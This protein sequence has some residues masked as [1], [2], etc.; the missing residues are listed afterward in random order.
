MS[1]V[2]FEWGAVVG[3]ILFSCGVGLFVGCDTTVPIFENPQDHPL[4]YS[5]YGQIS[6]SDGGIIRVEPLRDST[7]R[8]APGEA[9]EVVTFTKV[10]TGTVDTL[11]LASRR[12]DQ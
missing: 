8:G 4:Y 2:A 9:S 5:L 6:Y 1:H 11:Q 7:L 3:W 12:V 10:A